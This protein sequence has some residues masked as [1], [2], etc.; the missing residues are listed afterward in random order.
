MSAPPQERARPL[1]LLLDMEMPLV[2]RFGTAKMPLRDVLQLGAGSVI[3]LG[4]AP[5]N[6]VELLV[7]GRVVARGSAV[8][9]HGNYGV[10]IN[11]IA[12]DAVAPP[13]GGAA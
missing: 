7:N 6:G 2:L 8:S 13:E 10:R 3:D 1:G 12:L 4:S 9:V 5:E 11:E